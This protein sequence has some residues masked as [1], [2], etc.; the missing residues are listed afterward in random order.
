MG[1]STSWKRRRHASRRRSFRRPSSSPSTQHLSFDHLA[2]TS[3]L[4]YDLLLKS[5]WRPG[6]PLGHPVEAGQHSPLTPSGAVTPLGITVRRGRGGLGSA[7]TVLQEHDPSVPLAA[8][9]PESSIRERAPKFVVNGDMVFDPLRPRCQFN[10]NHVC[11]DLKMLRKHEQTCPDN[12]NRSSQ[13]MGGVSI[14]GNLF[15]ELSLDD[16]DTDEESD[17]VALDDFSDIDDTDD[18]QDN[19]HLSTVSDDLNDLGIALSTSV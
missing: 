17:H 11:R 6:A 16:D 2:I 4:G 8:S 9:A 7:Q 15:G 18:E 5:G 14:I 19:D 3:G 1:G 12:P 13:I 10:R